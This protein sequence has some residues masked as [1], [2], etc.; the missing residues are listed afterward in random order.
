MKKY[1]VIVLLLSVVCLY[2]QDG[3]GKYVIKNL[4][5]NTEQSEF[6]TAYHGDDKLI[7]AAP[8]RGFRV[9]RD[10]WEPNGQR[11]LDLY[12]ADISE[13]GSVANKRR[14]KGEVNSRYHEASVTFSK[15]GKTVYFTRDNYYNKKLGIDN[16]GYTNLAMFKATVN[17]KG[18]WINIIPMPFNNVEYSVGHPTL[19]ED[20]KTL[21]FTSDMP[22]SLGE[23]DI[24]KVEVNESGFGNPVNLGPN[25]NS[26]AKDWFPYVDGDVLYFSSTR[27]GGKGGVDIYAT[28]LKGYVAEPVNLSLNSASDDFAF[29]INSET[30]KGYFSS[31]REGGKGD[32]DIYSFIE[33]E[34]V[35]FKCLQLVTGDVRDQISTSLLPGSEVILSDKDGNVIETTI[36]KED[37]TFSFKISCETEYRLEGKKI[38][39]KPQ[40]ISF[41]T[42]SE[43]DKEIE[44]PLLLGAGN[45]NYAVNGNNGTQGEVEDKK[46]EGL[47]DVLPDEIVKLPGGDYGVNVDPIYF[48]LDSSYLNEQA[49]KELQKVVDLM[50]KY[51]KMIIEAASHTDSRAPAG[52][53]LWLSDKRAKRTV[54]YII[55]KGIDASRITGKGYG[56]TQLINGCDDN[57]KC[58]EAQHQQNRRSEFVIIRM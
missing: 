58:T 37:A 25:V 50:N 48:D 38:G 5:V 28:K 54:D 49:K 57:T 41:I 17:N 7:F 19:S 55:G 26:T 53:N 46:P 56:E 36:V 16:Q 11:F 30:R 45:I 3:G 34:E 1:L 52:Y 20:E 2:A 47:P 40:S 13:D 12:E 6:G 8:R 27:S 4:E 21:Y 22:G 29:I 14:L 39:F 15:D 32:D 10:V 35:D 24:Y 43:A 44:M 31:N 33:E 18:E 42:S 23:T 9:I 51:P